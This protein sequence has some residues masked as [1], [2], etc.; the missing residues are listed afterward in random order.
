MNGTEH[1]YKYNG[2]ELNEELGLDWYDF[3]V[4]N[5]DP[6]LGRWFNIDPMAEV[7]P[8]QSTYVYALNS[9]LFFIDPDGALPWPVH[10]RSFINPSSV[11]GGKFK[12][13]G[14][15]PSTQSSPEATS[16]VRTTFVVD[17]AKGSVSNPVSQ[18]DPTR[19]NGI[20][21]PTNTGPLLRPIEKT[22]EPSSSITNVETS[23][24]SVSLDFE[25]SGKDPITPGI[26][27]P[28]LD[29]QANLSITEDLDAGILNVT[30]EFTGDAFP[31]TEAFITDQ[32]GEGRLLL[33]AHKEQGGLGNL[34][35]EN[36]RP[37]FSVNMQVNIDSS[38][39]FTGV[40]QGDK[41]YTVSEWNQHVKDSFNN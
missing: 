37:T 1:P 6:A 41:T 33:G 27:T 16:R 14:R 7:M 17:P 36:K 25:H 31:S 12:G 29:V 11:A 3:G 19:F 5:Y 13:D 28:D 9:P 26:I 40:T 4:R 35:G 15:G 34:F 2:K 8:D 24:N 10:I 30:G 21:N 38:G 18:S 39:N 23:K 20:S 22:A 32:S